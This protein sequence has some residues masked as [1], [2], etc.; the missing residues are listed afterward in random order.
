MHTPSLA[1]LLLPHAPPAGQDFLSGGAEPL[2]QRGFALFNKSWLNLQTGLASTDFLPRNQTE[3]QRFYGSI[4]PQAEVDGALR[5]LDAFRTQTGAFGSPVVLKRKL[6]DD[7]WI[8]SHANPPQDLYAHIAWIS[9]KTSIACDYFAS[10]LRFC[11]ERICTADISIPERGRIL[12]DIFAGQGGLCPR[13]KDIEAETQGLSAR[14]A[15]FRGPLED[16]VVRMQAYFSRKDSLLESARASLGS[17]RANLAEVQKKTAEAYNAWIA[18]T[19][20]ASAGSVSLLVVSCWLIVPAVA[21]MIG[22][23]ALAGALGGAAAKQRQAYENLRASL[24]AKGEAVTGATRLVGDLDAFHKKMTTLLPD[25]RAFCDSVGMLTQSWANLQKNIQGFC[26]ANSDEALGRL[27]AAELLSN[28]QEAQEIWKNI[29]HEAE[30]FSKN[31]L[32]TFNFG[33]EFGQPLPPQ[34]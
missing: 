4:L 26:D 14:L 24:Q 9:Q 31:A 13:A 28:V 11:E 12:R 32:V 19:I 6:L 1:R 34:S 16:S 17:L 15:S 10:T 2:G 5:A 25:M 29:R 21:G 18:Y 27:P 3:W 33:P 7:P 23:P 22:A 8:L 30:D 20:G